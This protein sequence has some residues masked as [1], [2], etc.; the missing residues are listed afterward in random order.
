MPSPARRFV[1]PTVA[2]LLIAA[3]GW[4]LTPRER[5][6]RTAPSTPSEK[7]PTYFATDATLHSFDVAGRPESE[8]SATRIDYYQ[9]RDVWIMKQPRWRQVGPAEGTSGLWR[10]RADHG[11]MQGDQSHAHLSGN[12]VLRRRGGATPI[13]VTTE[14]LDLKPPESYAETA[15]P[16]LIASPDWRMRGVGAHMWLDRQHLELLADVEGVYDE[17]TH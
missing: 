8:L 14:T 16:V 7:L 15:D 9:G 5:V 4:W 17:K 10:G 12:V 13:T 2:F 11:R 3:V 6:Q 1:F